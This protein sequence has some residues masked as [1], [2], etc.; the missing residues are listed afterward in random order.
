MGRHFWWGN[1]AYRVCCRSQK[2]YGNGDK[3]RIVLVSDV[4]LE[5]TYVI[6]G[7]YINPSEIAH[8]NDHSAVSSVG[9]NE[10]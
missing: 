5:Y 4:R 9:S 6:Y 1:R 3:V 10:L 2:A 8:K 7:A